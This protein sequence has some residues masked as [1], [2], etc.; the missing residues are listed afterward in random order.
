[1]KFTT[2]YSLE[3]ETDL[4]SEEAYNLSLVNS[5][6]HLTD[7]K[8]FQCGK[9]CSFK[10]TLANFNKHSFK[11]NPYFTPGARNQRHDPDCQLMLKHYRQ[12]EQ[13]SIPTKKEPLFNREHS[14]IIIDLEQIK[15][16]LASF[17]SVET[18]SSS[19]NNDAQSL[20]SHS[21]PTVN[22]ENYHH[23][24]KRLNQL[25][26]LYLDYQSG[27]KY[28]FYLKDGQQIQL[29][30]YFVNLA[31]SKER[32]ISLADAHIYYDTAFVSLRSFASKSE[33]DYFLITLSSKCMLDGVITQPT[34]LINKK[35]A[36]H[37]GVK[38]KL[39]IL[40]KAAKDRKP[41]KIFYF[42]KFRKHTSNS[43]E[44]INPDVTSKKILDYLVIS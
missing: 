12:R 24:V 37:R 7:A 40:E 3:L 38:F 25:I 6:Y 33:N 19:R 26:N 15:E 9:N 36:N 11:K 29:E 42:G 1:M 13:E 27:E 17:G 35:L 2:A 32:E 10:L 28:I 43:R 34:I 23:Y 16:T 5:T 44:F 8:K 31:E 21:F 4:S 22:S 39:K 18:N 14:N 20:R 30:K 41:L